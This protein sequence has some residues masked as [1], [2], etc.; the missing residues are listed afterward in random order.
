MLVGESR[1]LFILN[2]FIYEVLD[3]SA[4]FSLNV[5]FVLLVFFKGVQSSAPD[6]WRIRIFKGISSA[7]VL[8]RLSCTRDSGRL[9]RDDAVV[10][11]TGHYAK[12]KLLIPGEALISL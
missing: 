2:Y 1:F 4:S 6:V 9:Q 7:A 8:T 11:F 3:Y 12:L 5:Q 10:G